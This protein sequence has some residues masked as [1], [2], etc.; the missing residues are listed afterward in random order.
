MMIL[1]NVAPFVRV[2]LCK[3]VGI[4]LVV[5]KSDLLRIIA[6]WGFIQVILKRHFK[7]LTQVKSIL[8]GLKITQGKR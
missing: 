2:R 4:S 8:K 5:L 3:R 7:C 1:L 6:I